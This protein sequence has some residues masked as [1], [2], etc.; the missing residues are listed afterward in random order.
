MYKSHGHVSGDRGKD[1]QSWGE[2]VP[3]LVRSGG[4]LGRVQVEHAGHGHLIGALDGVGIAVDI[5]DF[6]YQ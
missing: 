1:V 2:G 6:T 3:L 4:Q 5:I